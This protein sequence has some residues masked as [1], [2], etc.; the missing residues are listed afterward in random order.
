M[1]EFQFKRFEWPNTKRCWFDLGLHC[2][3]FH[4]LYWL[5]P[6]R[7]KSDQFRPNVPSSPKGIMDVIDRGV[8]KTVRIY[9]IWLM[10]ECVCV[11][12]VVKD[13]MLMGKLVG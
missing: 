7:S 10:G 9:Q 12:V 8:T 6:I 2:T 1:V 3:T 11:F 4:P 5:L 13:N